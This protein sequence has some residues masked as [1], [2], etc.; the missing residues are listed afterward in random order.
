MVD[1]P[2]NTGADLREEKGTGG[3]AEYWPNHVQQSRIDSALG[4]RLSMPKPNK[5][6]TFRDSFH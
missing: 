6:Q 2:F 4:M 1:C 3:V 5:N